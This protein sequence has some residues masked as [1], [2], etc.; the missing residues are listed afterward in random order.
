M[1]PNQI[2]AIELSVG[3]ANDNDKV[4]VSCSAEIL[5]HRIVNIRQDL[6][7]VTAFRLLGIVRKTTDALKKLLP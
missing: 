4:D 1:I 6:D 5:G 3:D 2:A 7:L